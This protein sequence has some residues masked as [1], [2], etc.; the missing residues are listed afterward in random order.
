MSGPGEKINEIYWLV[1][2]K[3]GCESHFG[4]RI[5]AKKK[6]GSSIATLKWKDHFHLWP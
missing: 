6:F 5:F 3:I 2:K 1:Q 4:K